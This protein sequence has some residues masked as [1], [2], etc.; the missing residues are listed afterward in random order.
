MEERGWGG[1]GEGTGGV[2][3][4]HM[5]SRSRMTVDSRRR[6]EGVEGDGDG[7]VTRL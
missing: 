3:S 2:R 4:F 6:E 5:H 1:V 7:G